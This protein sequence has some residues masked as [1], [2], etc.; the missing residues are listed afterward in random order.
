MNREELDGWL[1]V[2]ELTGERPVLRLLLEWP[3]EILVGRDSSIQKGRKEGWGRRDP[4]P[5]N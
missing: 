1:E 5:K 3:K 4:I 2:S